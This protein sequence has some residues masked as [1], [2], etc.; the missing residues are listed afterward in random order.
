MLKAQRKHPRR[1]LRIGLISLV[2]LALA[3]GGYW[4]WDRRQPCP[5]TKIYQGVI[6]RCERMPETPESGGLVHIVE[7]DM[8]APGVEPYVTNIDPVAKA[9]G[10][11]YT[12]DY[13]G[14][15]VKEKHLAVGVNGTLFGSNSGWVRMRGDEARSTETVVSEH[16]VNHPDPI[17]F[18]LWFDDDF[19]P[20]L[21]H[22][23]PATAQTLARMRFGIGGQEEILQNGKP[24]PG[25][26]TTPDH[27]TMLAV[28]TSR[29]R[30]WIA[31]FEKASFRAAAEKLGQLGAVQGMMLDG[32]T[33]S[34]MALG[35]DANGVRSGVV[36]G[37]WRP[38]PVQF[39]IRARPIQK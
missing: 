9:H 11:E 33:S 30:L 29:K 22:D 16:L 1:R 8:T 35:D 18:M 4:W 20:H 21:E 31:V 7:V 12:L 2:V 37:N 10:W 26:T 13:V 15:V 25:T 14:R 38:V 34:A 6:Y 27:R 39:G 32:G 23:R 3:G 17:S 5:P 24:R 28:D 19:T 36:M